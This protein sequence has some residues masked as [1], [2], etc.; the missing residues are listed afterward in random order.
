MGSLKVIKA[1]LKDFVSETSISG[2]NNSGKCKSKV[3]SSI[4]LVIFTVLAYFTANGIYEIVVD[5]FEY[6]VITNTDLTYK[7]EVDFPAVTICNLN[8]V[9]CHNAFQAM[10]SIKQTIR[11]NLSLEKDE[12]TELQTA[13]SQ[14]DYLLSANVTNCQYPI[15]NS[16]KSEVKI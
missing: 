9:N 6:P 2:I 10:Y 16:L 8:R 15:C 11:S 14:L 7:S 12:M 13:Q 5:F 3:R 4:W 1:T